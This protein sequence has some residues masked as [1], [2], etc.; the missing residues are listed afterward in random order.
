VQTAVKMGWGELE[1]GDLLREA[2]VAG[3]TAA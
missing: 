3:F 2:E 1:D